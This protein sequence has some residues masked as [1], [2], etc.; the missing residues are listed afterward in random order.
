MPTRE[1]INQKYQKIHDDITREYYENH[2][3]D[4]QTFNQLHGQNWQDHENELIQYGYRKRIWTYQFSKN[5]AGIGTIIGTIT[6][7]RELTTAE[8]SDI[9]KSYDK[10]D[11]VRISSVDV[12]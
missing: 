4:E 11:E 8:I 6:V 7:E 5:V 9:K 1:E 3:I 2:S 12:K 10:F